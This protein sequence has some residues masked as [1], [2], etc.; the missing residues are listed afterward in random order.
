L[1]VR[2]LGAALAVSLLAPVGSVFAQDADVTVDMQGIQFAPTEIHIPAGGT[3]LWTN[4]SPIGHTVTADD[5][6]YDSGN[7]NQGDTFSTSFDAPGTYSYYCIPHKA[8]GMVAV[9]V[10]DD[11]NAMSDANPVE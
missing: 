7:I 9:V 8:A 4:S 3:V 11:P 10:V 5:G 2:V 6:S 1:C